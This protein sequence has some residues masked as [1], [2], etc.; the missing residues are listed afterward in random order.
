MTG[1][2]LIIFFFLR[3]FSSSCVTVQMMAF[4]GE[5]LVLMHI[6]VIM[7]E[8]KLDGD[9]NSVSVPVPIVSKY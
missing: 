9:H 3:K 5:A 8:V 2:H 6:E 1:H 7:K 4:K